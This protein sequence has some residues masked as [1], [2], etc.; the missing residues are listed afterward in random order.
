MLVRVAMFMFII[1]SSFLY[2]QDIETA[3]TNENIKII[4]NLE[5]AVELAKENN[6]TY[7][8]KEYD[9]KIAKNQKEQTQAD[10]Y[11][12]S[13]SAGATVSLVK[14]RELTGGLDSSIDNY[15]FQADLSKSL[16]TGFRTWNADKAKGVNLKMVEE[17]YEEAR[18]DLIINTSLNFFNT[19]VL[20][21]TYRIYQ[22]SQYSISNRMRFLEIQY[23]N[24]IVSEYDYLNIKV[25]YENTKPNLI[26][27]SN[28]YEALKL[29]F[30]RSIGITN[31]NSEVELSGNLYDILLLDTPNINDELLVGKIMENNSQLKTMQYNIEML[32]YNKKIAQG[33]YYPTLALFAGAST[34][35]NDTISTTMNGITPSYSKDR[36]WGAN[37]QAGLKLTYQLDS[38]I[39]VSSTSKKAKEVDLNIKKMELTYSELKDNIEV[40]SRTLISTA[41]SQEEMLS[42]QA[43]NAKTAKYAFEMATKSYQAGQISTLEVS[44]SEITYLNAELAYVKSIYDYYSSI[45]QIMKLLGNRL[46]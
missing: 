9:L 35:L 34:S 22:T 29:S 32:E 33:F 4:L 1:L 14:P 20:K 3:Q 2:S 21:E 13:L 42:S 16:F 31:K 18:K 43:E 41:I 6:K 28:N 37:W 19:M 8:Q 12:P 39:P 10:L 45:L 24:G 25:Q 40:S 27:I 7:K 46:E 17:Q 5:K 44:D 30:L 15:T 26:T 11:M 36:E 23:R 38:L